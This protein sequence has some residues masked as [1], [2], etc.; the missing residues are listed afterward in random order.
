[1]AVMAQSPG[2][3]TRNRFM[4]GVLTAIG[5]AIGI[6]YV[7]VLLRYLYPKSSET[8]PL[9]VQLGPDGVTPPGAAP[10]PW[11]A[12]VAGPFN[13][14]PVPDKS[15]VV[16]VFVQQLTQND[17]FTTSNLRVVEQ[18]CTHLGCPVAWV[19]KDYRFECPCHG[20]QFS[21]KTLDRVAG[22]APRPL[23]THAFK[24]SGSTLTILKQ[25]S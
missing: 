9:D 12:G 15:V 16:G 20:S 4:L 1:M 3:V 22:P 19:P 11:Q 6:A 17:D 10:L 8:P 14:P 21:G 5:G 2:A 18:T 23:H 25:N 13:Y 7:G 24:L